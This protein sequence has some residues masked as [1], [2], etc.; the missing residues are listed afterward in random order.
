M[1][2]IGL[3]FTSSLIPHPSSL[4]PPIRHAVDLH[5]DG[6][7]RRCLHRGPGGRRFAEEARVDFVHGP[8]VAGVGQ[9]DIGLHH[10]PQRAAGS[11][12]DRLDILQHL[13]R[14]RRDAALDLFADRRVDR[15]LAG[16]VDKFAGHHRL[17]VRPHRLRGLLGTNNLL[18]SFSL[19]HSTTPGSAPVWRSGSFTTT[20][21]T[22][23]HGI[24][25]GYLFGSSYDA[26]SATRA[27]SI[28]AR[29]AAM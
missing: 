29:S 25:T 19:C 12:Q 20:P 22:T 16:D 5:E 10:I 11:L 1:R 18:H 4:I 27:G 17:R 8:E 3:S 21:F 24:P 13:F 2:P 23:T 14:L 15:P 7:G 26:V 6:Y 9:V 28:S